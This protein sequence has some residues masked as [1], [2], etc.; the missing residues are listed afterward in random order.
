MAVN[1]QKQVIAINAASTTNANTATGVV[2]RLGWDYMTLDVITTTSNDT[3]NNPSVLKLQQSDTT[4]ATNYADISGTVGDTDWTIP[5]AVT[6]RRLPGAVA[7]YPGAGVAGDNADD[8]R[9]R[10]P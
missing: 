6:Q 4:D 10:E 2:D 8:Y 5:A 9:Y 7:L 1:D 3:T